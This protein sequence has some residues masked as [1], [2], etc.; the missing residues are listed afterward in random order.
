[1]VE[2]EVERRLSVVCRAHQRRRTRLTQPAGPPAGQE[3]AG[4]RRV[5]WAWAGSAKTPTDWAAAAME[6]RRCGAVGEDHGERGSGPLLLDRSQG[7]AQVGAAAPWR[8]A[9]REARSGPVASSPRAAWNGSGQ[10]PAFVATCSRPAGVSE[11]SWSPCLGSSASRVR[12]AAR[13]S[14]RCA[15]HPRPRPPPCQPPGGRRRNARPDVFGGE[16]GLRPGH[17]SAEDRSPGSRRRPRWS[18]RANSL[19][20]SADAAIVGGAARLSAGISCLREET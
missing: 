16:W 10:G 12:I 6:A 17:P 13:T 5:V 7:H 19:L 2:H 20:T 18:N 15:R 11:A 1:M 9:F 14:P 4:S 8:T 3:R